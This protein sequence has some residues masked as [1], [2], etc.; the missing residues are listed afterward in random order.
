M[1]IIQLK[2]FKAICEYNGVSKAAEALYV[3]QPAITIAIKNLEE[4]FGASLFNRNS[5]KF[6]LTQAGKFL[7][8]RVDVVLSNL[9]DLE[10]QMRNVTHEINSIKVGIPPIVSTFTFKDIVVDYKQT[11]KDVNF[12]V[13]EKGSLDVVRDV[14]N[15]AL[16][17][18]IA[19]IKKGDVNNNI[20][21]KELIDT[22]FYVL[23][24]KN[25]HLASRQSLSY[26]DLEKENII[27]F[28]KGSYQHKHFLDE[29]KREG[30]APKIFLNAYQLTTINYCLNNDNYVAILYKDVVPLLHDVVGIRLERPYK[31]KIGLVYN[32]NNVLSKNAKDFI[33]Y[34][35]NLYKNK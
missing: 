20:E 31:V 12:E 7:L 5:N 2:Y 17:V 19:A 18:G 22:E 24:N 34:I 30:I 11:H 14:E 10:N 27:L 25:H 26:R 16:E 15:G 35:E 1:K 4:E 13:T 23:V 28:N 6:E 3:T 29:F 32:K 33:E 21:F 9:E 8:E